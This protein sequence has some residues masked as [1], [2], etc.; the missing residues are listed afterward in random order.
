M[1]TRMG[2][3]RRRAPDAAPR[4]RQVVV[5]LSDDELAAVKASAM[6]AGLAVGAW[7]GDVAARSTRK[8]G[9]EL[10]VSRA[11]VVGQLVRVR[12][13][14]ALIEKVLCEAD[15]LSGRRLAASAV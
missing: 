7:L 3:V 4:R 11:E 12:L 2:V 1:V 6:E 15:G 10:G 9:W 5:R 13:D 8:S 14:V